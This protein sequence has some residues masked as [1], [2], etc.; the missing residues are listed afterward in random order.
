MF[1]VETR[2]F[3][4]QGAKGKRSEIG[5]SHAKTQRREDGLLNHEMHEMHE[6]CVSRFPFSC[7][8]VHSVVSSS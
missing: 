7:P 2:K 1:M 8:S 6:S 5:E 3:G 4:R